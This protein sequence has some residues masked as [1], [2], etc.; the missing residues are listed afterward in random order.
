[1]ID[2]DPHIN[3]PPRGLAVE[4][5]TSWK[6]PTSSTGFEPVKFEMK[7]I[8]KWEIKKLG[9][10]MERKSEDG[11]PQEKPTNSEYDH[12]RYKSAS[13]KSWTCKGSH[14]NLLL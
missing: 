3:I 4:T 6:N 2:L 5:F 10:E 11:E 13:T 8:N 12:Q 1:M 7:Q 9:A 14:I